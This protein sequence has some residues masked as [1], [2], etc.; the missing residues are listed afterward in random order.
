MFAITPKGIGKRV[1]MR[2]VRDG[3]TL[4]PTEYIVSSYTEG[5]V[6][7]ADGVSLEPASNEIPPTKAERIAN[8]TGGDD[9]TEVLF[10]LLFKLNNRVRVLEGKPVITSIQFI[11]FLEGELN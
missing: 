4:A 11:E 5:D 8:I 2:R 10:S 3:W 1:G 9:K 7:G 6:L